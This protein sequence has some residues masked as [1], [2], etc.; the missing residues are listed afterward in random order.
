MRIEEIPRFWEKT[1]G[2]HYECLNVREAH[3]VNGRITFHYDVSVRQTTVREQLSFDDADAFYEYLM[4]S[5]YSPSPAQP[6]TLVNPSVE[7]GESNQMR[8]IPSKWYREVNEEGEASN[9]E[10][11]IR[12]LRQRGDEI[13]CYFREESINGSY[14]LDYDRCFK[15]LRAFY[16]Y[17]TG[18]A[19]FRDMTSEP[20]FVEGMVDSKKT[21]TLRDDISEYVKI[22][23]Q[24]ISDLEDSLLIVKIGTEKRPAGQ[25]DI[26]EMTE[27]LKEL[28]K[29]VKGLKT[30][31]T[32]HAIDF[33]KLDLKGLKKLKFGNEQEQRDAISDLEI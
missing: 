25:A 33:V 11:I 21:T 8:S 28:F 16:N 32:H 4:R 7:R 5:Q 19:F 20:I 23:T 17:L 22:E 6:D 9:D 14:G 27:K 2:E 10:V 12:R 30:M 3:P 1:E 31:V 26:E 29:D 13:N 15:D 18:H 24:K